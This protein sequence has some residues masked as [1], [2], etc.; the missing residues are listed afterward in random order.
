MKDEP[1]K[2]PIQ[3]HQPLDTVGTETK[4]YIVE[5]LNTMKLSRCH[6]IATSFAKCGSYIKNMFT[7]QNSAYRFCQQLVSVIYSMLP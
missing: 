2:N 7:L 3:T 4:L 5:Q 1:P 6:Y